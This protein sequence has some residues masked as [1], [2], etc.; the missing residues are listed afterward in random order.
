MVGKVIVGL[1]VYNLQVNDHIYPINFLLTGDGNQ[2]QKIGL[3]TIS[4]TLEIRLASKSPGNLT[5]VIPRA[6]LDKIEPNSM[7]D[8][9]GVVA[10]RAVG[11]EETST[12]PTS[13]TLAIQFDPGVNYIQVMGTK[14]V[15]SI[16]T[17]NDTKVPL[18]QE[19]K[20]MEKTLE[21]VQ[22]LPP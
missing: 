21:P 6:L 3:Q 16:S 12:S 18:N 10:N 13:R 20:K 1:Y 14:S 8:A 2:L 9:F 15:Q 22:N 7:D 19:T 17:V 4:P 11:F 5:L